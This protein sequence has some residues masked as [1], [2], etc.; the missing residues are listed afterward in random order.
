MIPFSKSTRTVNIIDKKTLLGLPAQ[1]LHE[2]LSFVPGV[3]VRTRG[4]RG[5]QA[6]VSIRGGSFDQTLFLVNGFKVNDPQTGH[7]G[8]NLPVLLEDAD[9]VEV[10]KGSTSRIFGAGGLAGAVNIITRVPETLGVRFGMYA[11]SYGNT[12]FQASASLP[13]KNYHQKIS[14]NRVAATGDTT[15][16]DFVYNNILYQSE[17]KADEG[18][19]RLMGGYTGNSFGANSFYSASFPDQW[20]KTSLLFGSME[21]ETHIGKLTLRP[22]F[23]YRRHTDEFRLKRFDPDFYENK[24]KT[25]V[26]SGELHASY[27][28]KA[29]ITGIGIEFKHEEIA[30]TNLDTFNRQTLGVYAEHRFMFFNR[31]NLIPG[32]YVNQFSDLGWKVYPGMEVSYNV[33][34]SLTVFGSGA[35]SMRVPTYTDWYYSDPANVGNPNLV[36]ESA[37]NYEGGLRWYQYNGLHVEAAYFERRVENMIDYVRDADTLPWAAS[38][39]SR[40]KMYGIESQANINFAELVSPKVPINIRLGYTW[41]QSDFEKGANESRYALNNLT[42]QFTTNLSYSLFKRFTHSV[43]A[44]Y[45]DRF[46][47]QKYWLIDT[48][49]QVSFIQNKCSIFAEVTNLLDKRYYEISTVRM[50]KRWFRFGLNVN[51]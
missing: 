48:K 28:S 39:L 3:D 32:V 50:P 17:V 19:F 27:Q 34:K 10:L 6:D 41:L 42:H 40:L 21:Y 22:R 12:G 47:G 30:S 18:T 9:R 35:R 44:K 33:W 29:G 20:E 1:S 11:G 23:S 49:A 16:M 15:N 2:A 31:L 51:L 7:H 37:W 26:S 36:P 8:M 13:Y 25:N 4:A 38:N 14:L 24:H 45:C 5:V 43:T 46:N